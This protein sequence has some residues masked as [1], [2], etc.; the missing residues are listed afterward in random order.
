MDDITPNAIIETLIIKYDRGKHEENLR[1]ELH[2]NSAMPKRMLY[3]T[4]WSI[5]ESF[6]NKKATKELDLP[7]TS[8]W[9]ESPSYE[10]K[11]IN[12][13]YS[14]FEISTIS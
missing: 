12:T 3:C 9:D 1:Q 4:A 14:K 5:V 13:K 8:E 7:A 2:H 11:C 6:V 10:T